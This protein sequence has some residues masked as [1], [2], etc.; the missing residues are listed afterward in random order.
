MTIIEYLVNKI[1][2]LNRHSFFKGK[3]MEE[4]MPFISLWLYHKD[5]YVRPVGSAWYCEV[6]KERAWEYITQNQHLFDEYYKWAD[7]QR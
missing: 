4:W 2:L 1:A 5:I 7:E 6:S 3:D